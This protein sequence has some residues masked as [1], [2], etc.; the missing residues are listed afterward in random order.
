M[1][2]QHSMKLS[3]YRRLEKNLRNYEY[4]DMSPIE[5]DLIMKRFDCMSLGKVSMEYNIIAS[6]Q[7]DWLVITFVAEL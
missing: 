6:N 5:I 3:K 1:I 7:G 2:S 4:S